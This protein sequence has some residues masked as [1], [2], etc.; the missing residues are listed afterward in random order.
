[1]TQIADA[2]GRIEGHFTIP[3]GI[4]PGTKLVKF[5]GKYNT[6]ATALYTGRGQV[7]DATYQS[8]ITHML[9][10]LV[11]FD[12]AYTTREDQV[13]TVPAATGFL[14]NCFSP[15]GGGP[16]ILT[17][18][19]QPTSGGVQTGAATFDDA[20]GFVFTPA[21]GFVGLVA[22]VFTCRDSFGVNGSACAFI[23]VIEVNRP[24]IAED[25]S[26][27]VYRDTPR[28][29]NVIT[30]D[31][32]PDGN[33]LVLTGSTS[34]QHGA[35]QTQ[36]NGQITY[37]PNSGFSGIDSFGYTITD[38]VNGLSSS[39]TVWLHVNKLRLKAI[40]DWYDLGPSI[41]S[42]TSADRNTG[43][44][45]P[46]LVLDN[47]ETPEPVTIVAVTQPAQ[48]P[49]YNTEIAISGDGQSVTCRCKPANS[50]SW[51]WSALGG[52]DINITFKYTIRGVNSGVES[53]AIARAYR[54]VP[55]FV[56]PLA[57][58]FVFDVSR[59][60][61]GVDVWVNTK[62]VG[63][64][65]IELRDVVYGI[66]DQPPLARGS[67]A[68]ESI[69]EGAWNRI[70]FDVPFTVTR[71]KN[72]AFV[73]MCGDPIT[74]LGIAEIG[75][76]DLDAEEWVT[77]QP[78]TIGV[79]LTSSNNATW[80]PHQNSDVTFRVL[81]KSFST[82]TKRVSLG[83]VA[84]SGDTDFLV[85][86]DVIIPAVGCSVEFELEMPSGA[87]YTV[88]AHQPLA[89]S[90]PETGSMVVTAVL[91]GTEGFTPVLGRNIT[92]LHGP[93]QSTGTYATRSMVAGGTDNRVRCIYEAKLPS[94]SSVAATLHR[95]QTGVGEIGAASFPAATASLL[96]DGYVEY[97]HELTAV[98]ADSVSVTLTVSGSAAARPL[99]RNFRAMVM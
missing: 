70:M 75:K 35:I 85:A 15:N 24:P 64:L 56:D 47:D 88:S 51:S 71:N 36:A 77:S 42:L 99:V 18:I 26:I 11:V 61:F 30:N 3:Q 87:I 76:F 2:N 80:T 55:R 12:S 38:T 29:F 44:P 97:S 22:I 73:A 58:T 8:E 54:T 78:F 25:D 81:S 4:S 33:S 93:I 48:G 20:G 14:T 37:V 95:F 6:I 89:L 74:E 1:M 46:L 23:D 32:S 49:I 62:G 52:V 96:D 65:A 57:Q 69:V 68:L 16:L 39:A 83:T 60:L 82:L 5:V 27:E 43:A 50:A 53:T 28:T 72:Y 86:A 67:I 19:S 91:V 66:P 21:I 17:S 45:I 10:P 31:S 59:Q 98:S 7:I 79:M 41:A 34:P 90:A 84:L 94:G 40:A 9:K 92:V 13:L 63:P